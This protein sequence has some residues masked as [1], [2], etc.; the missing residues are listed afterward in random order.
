MAEAVEYS[1]QLRIDEF[2]EIQRVGLLTERE[3]R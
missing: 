1:M 3:L 2:D